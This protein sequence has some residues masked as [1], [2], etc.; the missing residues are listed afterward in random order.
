[1]TQEKQND[2]KLGLQ[3]LANTKMD[4]SLIEWNKISNDILAE[5]ER[6]QR[7]Q[8]ALTELYWAINEK[9]RLGYLKSYCDD[10][11]QTL[12]DTHTIKPQDG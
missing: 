9:D 10:A 1:M 11:Q 7:M 2:A 3:K 6:A 8:G 5:L 4:L 12:S